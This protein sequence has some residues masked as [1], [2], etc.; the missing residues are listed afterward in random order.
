MNETNSEVF[1]LRKGVDA[2]E[3]EMQL[4]FLWGAFNATQTT[5]ERVNESRFH[6]DVHKSLVPPLNPGVAEILASLYQCS[7]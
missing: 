1:A 5:T 4:R 2:D 6:V 7:R 3:L